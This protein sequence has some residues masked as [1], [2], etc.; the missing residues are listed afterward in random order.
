MEFHGNFP[1]QEFFFHSY[2][3][4]KVPKIAPSARD[5][6]DRALR[7][8]FATRASSEV[9]TRQGSRYCDVGRQCPSWSHVEYTAETQDRDVRKAVTRLV[10][11][12]K[13]SMA[14]TT[15]PAWM[16]FSTQFSSSELMLVLA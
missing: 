1:Y 16:L 8:L 5:T 15:Y 10:G 2:S 3:Y 11:Y 12:A 9:Y 7:A 14:R 13:S 4:G 6:L